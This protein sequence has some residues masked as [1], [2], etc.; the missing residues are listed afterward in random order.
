MGLRSLTCVILGMH[1]GG[2]RNSCHANMKRAAYSQSHNATSALAHIDVC[3]IRN[4]RCKCKYYI[5]HLLTN[6][7]ST[8]VE[9]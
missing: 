2:C 1:P 7:E 4:P 9:E 3:I 5:V 8:A 6:F